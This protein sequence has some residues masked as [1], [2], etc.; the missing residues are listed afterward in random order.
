MGLKLSRPLL[1]C[2]YWILSE[3][4]SDLTDDS[5]EILPAVS[6]LYRASEL[7]GVDPVHEFLAAAG[8]AGDPPDGTLKR[9]LQRSPE[10][11]RIERMGFAEDEAGF[12]FRFVG[13]TVNRPS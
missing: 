11:R 7:V 12:R 4:A 3:L 5:R 13:L 1:I 9:Y 10:R 8:L 6:L 2:E